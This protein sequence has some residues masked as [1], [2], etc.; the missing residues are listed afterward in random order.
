MQPPSPPDSVPSGSH[1]YSRVDVWLVAV[2]AVVFIAP[3]L[4]LELRR[5]SMPDLSPALVLDAGSVHPSAPEARPLQDAIRDVFLEAAVILEGIDRAS[6]DASSLSALDRL[7]AQ[8]PSLETSFGA[9]S[10]DERR[11]VTEAAREELARFTAAAEVILRSNPAPSELQALTRE[12]RVALNGFAHGG[13]PVEEILY[14]TYGQATIVLQKVRTQTLPVAEAVTR[15]HHYTDQAGRLVP[16]FGVLDGEHRAR[17]REEA[18]RQWSV[19]APL[20]ETASRSPDT[21]EEYRQ[22]TAQLLA[23]L[24]EFSR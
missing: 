15:L 20:A 9:L 10:E 12:L 22:L 14:S 13:N 6:P 8:L 16:A 23:M 17:A 19:F 24:Q 7:R 4:F 18:Q 11:P 5:H 1:A 3:V 2:M 21:S